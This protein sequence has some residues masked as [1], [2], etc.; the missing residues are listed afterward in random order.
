MRSLGEQEHASV[1]DSG[2]YMD[3]TQEQQYVLHTSTT[4]PQLALLAR[5]FTSAVHSL[6]SICIG[7]TGQAQAAD[8]A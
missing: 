4:Y 8:T 1:G 6:I 2:F 3:G 7:W 5:N